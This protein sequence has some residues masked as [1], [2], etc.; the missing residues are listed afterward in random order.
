MC[1]A[2]PLPA[3]T[4]EIMFYLLTI[5]IATQVCAAVAVLAIDVDIQSGGEIST[6]H[7]PLYIAEVAGDVAAK[8]VGGWGWGWLQV[9][10]AAL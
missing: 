6:S 10:L 9:W 8:G 3:S 4:S 2:S 5:Y 1:L 7:S